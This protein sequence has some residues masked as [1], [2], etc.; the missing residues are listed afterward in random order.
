VRAD[1]F[2]DIVLR[3]GQNLLKCLLAGVADELVVGHIDHSIVL[4][5]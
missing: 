3:D 2:F 1:G 5:C 4:G